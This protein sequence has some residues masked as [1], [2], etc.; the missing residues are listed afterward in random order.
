VFVDAG[1]AA[2]KPTDLEPALGYGVGLR[3]RTPIGPLRLDV[4]YGARAHGVRVH[5]SVGLAF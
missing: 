3:V 2:D 5:F 1:N 4:A